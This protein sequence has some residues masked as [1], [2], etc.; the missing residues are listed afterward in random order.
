MITMLNR[1]E[2]IVVSTLKQYS[3][4]CRLLNAEGI[5]NRTKMGGGIG[6]R[7]GT[8][9][10]LT[11]RYTIYVHEKDYDRALS[12]IQSAMQETVE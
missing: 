11:E 4:I 7:R 9:G 6:A 8:D 1:R 3:D 12:L 5:R 10:L 2:L